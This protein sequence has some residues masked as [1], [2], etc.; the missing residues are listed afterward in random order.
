M[1]I[2][3]ILSFICLSFALICPLPCF[4][5]APSSSGEPE[6]LF[7]LD[8]EELASLTITTASRNPETLIDAPAKVTVITRQQIVERG[9]INL[10]DL[11]RDLPGVDVHGY[12]HETT[13]NRIVMRGVEGSNKFIIQQDGIPVG[14]PAGDPIP[15]ADNFPLFNA[16][17]VEVVY[18]PVSALYGADAFTGIINIVTAGGRENEA[19]A[20]TFIGEDGYRY[21]YG[22]GD[23]RL[24]DK[25]RLNFAGHLHESDNPNLTEYYGDAFT[26]EDLIDF[27]DNVAVP[28]EER[29]GY[30]GD[31][32]SHTLT[33][34]LQLG[35]NF[36]MGYHQSMFESPTTSGMLPNS[37]DYNSHGSWTTMVRTLYGTYDYELTPNLSVH[38]RPL[39][40]DY[41]VDPS[42]KFNNIFS[43]YQDGYKYAESDKT[44]LDIQF[45]YSPDT[46]NTFVLGLV[47]AHVNSIA[48]TPDLMI[49][50]APDQTA[51]EQPLYY[52]GTDETIPVKIFESCYDNYGTYLQYRRSWLPQF[53]TIVGARYDDSS[54]YG[55]SFNPRLGLI[56]KPSGRL[57]TK[58]LY[59]EAFLAPAPE[60]TF[61]HYGAFS[62]N[63]NGDGLYTSNFFFV[64]NDD[65]EPEK[66]RTI[67]ANL[68]Y[69]LSS[70]FTLGL[71]MYHTRVDNMILNTGMTESASDFI[72]GGIIANTSHNDNIGELKVTGGDLEF[73]HVTVFDDS[74]LKLWG[75]YS[76]TNSK[77][78]DS[79]QN[80]EVDRTFVPTNKVKLGLTFR[81]KEK[82][83]LTPQFYWVDTVKTEVVELV[84]GGT[85]PEEVRS[86]SLVNLHAGID[87]ILPGLSLSLRVDNLFDRRYYNAGTANTVTFAESP[88]NPRLII[89][90]LRYTY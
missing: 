44:Q 57:T 39:Y 21:F 75:N 32:D 46:T 60:F 4:A 42:S 27:G 59:G 77:L 35:E 29:E 62:G 87:D 1:K 28:A 74:S 40:A 36:K 52:T 3:Q 70:R 85:S 14:S 17:R 54:R 88:Q 8:L 6:N 83:F 66:I 33:L 2:L 45:N 24:S 31:T 18:G 48:K 86:Y 58:L 5:T 69:M 15:V 53:D 56:Y 82:Y 63:I 89:F 11:M 49:P 30:Y 10:V 20:G 71:S 90:G 41:E 68:S 43:N 50:Y 51:S 80:V 64:P 23:Y 65:L 47:A 67:E 9:Y 16:L 72:D 73:S 13:Y 19:T 55:G 22:S 78:E 76:Y 38:L 84:G 25:V 26:L 34:G 12:S 81:Y 37:V 79:K 61:E 7:D